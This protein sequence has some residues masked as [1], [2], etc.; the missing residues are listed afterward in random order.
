MFAIHY[1]LIF[2]LN[3]GNII[4]KIETHFICQMENNQKIKKRKSPKKR[5]DLGEDI[6]LEN[7]EEEEKEKNMKINE[8]QDSEIKKEMQKVVRDLGSEKCKE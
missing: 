7:D 1:Y 5:K 4:K 3:K 6:S 8:N 2:D